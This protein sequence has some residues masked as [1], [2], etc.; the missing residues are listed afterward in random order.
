[1]KALKFKKMMYLYHSNEELECGHE[2]KRREKLWI[3]MGFSVTQVYKLLQLGRKKSFS[4]L[5]KQ[6]VD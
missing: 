4:D 1:M 6:L 2:Y 3:M 5:F